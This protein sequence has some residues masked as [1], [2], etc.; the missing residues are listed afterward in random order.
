[1]CDYHTDF[2]KNSEACFKINEKEL[3]KVTGIYKTLEI[4]NSGSFTE[5]DEKTMKKIEEVCILKGIT[6]LH[7]ESHWLK[8]DNIHILKEHFKK[9]G[10]NVKLKIGVE[11]FDYY[12]R[13]SYLKKGMENISPE[14]ISKY[15][16]EICLLQGIA[17]QSVEFMKKDIETGLKYFERVCIN[18]MQKNTTHILPDPNVKKIFLEEIY[19][20]Y[21]DNERIDILLNNTDFG[22]GGEKND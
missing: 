17:G 18:I 20:I 13:E 22:V 3:N 5:L 7:F 8:K 21:K 11:T 14:E 2:N 19:P 10:I 4:I 6:K 1:F 16:D 15:F 9:L 12:F